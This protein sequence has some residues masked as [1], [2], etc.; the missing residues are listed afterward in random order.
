MWVKILAGVV[1]AL[2]VVGVGVYVALPPGD[3]C[4]GKSDETPKHSCCSVSSATCSN[5]VAES[6]SHAAVSDACPSAGG[7]CATST[8]PNTDALAACTGGMGVSTSTK[9]S[10]KPKFTCCS[11]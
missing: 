1:A 4:S 11:E 7:C 9:S 10:A 6:C 8:V 2:A 5:E 3:C